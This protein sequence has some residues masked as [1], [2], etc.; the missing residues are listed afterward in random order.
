MQTSQ[1]M[2]RAWESV[3][4]PQEQQSWLLGCQHGQQQVLK[5]HSPAPLLQPAEL[6]CRH[7]P[8]LNLSACRPFL[9]EKGCCRHYLRKAQLQDLLHDV[10]DQR[11]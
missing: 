6:H 4:P 10:K 8:V 3:Q 11:K 7:L 1:L 9:Y 5:C 2:T